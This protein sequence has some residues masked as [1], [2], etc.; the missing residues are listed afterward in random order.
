MPGR[1]IHHDQGAAGGH[2]RRQPC[3]HEAGIG[4]A[5]QAAAGDEQHGVACGQR[6]REIGLDAVGRDVET[7]EKLRQGKAIAVVENC[8][9]PGDDG[10]DGQGRGRRA[11]LVIRHHGQVQVGHT[12]VFIRF[13]RDVGLRLG[14]DILALRRVPDLGNA[15]ALPLVVLL[16]RQLHIEKQIAPAH[17]LVGNPHRRELLAPDVQQEQMRLRRAKI[18]RGI[19]RGVVAVHAHVNA[20]QVLLDPRAIQGRAKVFA[21]IGGVDQGGVG[22]NR[23]ASTVIDIDG[24]PGI[25]AGLVRGLVGRNHDVIVVATVLELANDLIGIGAIALVHI[26]FEQLPLL[27]RFDQGV[28]HGLV[29][30]SRALRR[31]EEERADGRGQPG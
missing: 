6:R 19:G 24:K 8:H 13:T 23:I 29:V 22:I 30:V 14:Q 17:D 1:L 21:R 10:T 15:A 5:A 11:G 12:L 9:L 16:R 28:G 18:E 27:D 20:L 2:V 7:V 25:G 4:V 31:G 3:L 26:G